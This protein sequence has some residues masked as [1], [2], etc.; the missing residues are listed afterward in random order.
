[1]KQP[2]NEEAQ[3]ARVADRKG[4]TSSHMQKKNALGYENVESVDGEDLVADSW[5]NKEYV[6]EFS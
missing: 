5:F 1:M 4:L 6:V 2:L 3:E